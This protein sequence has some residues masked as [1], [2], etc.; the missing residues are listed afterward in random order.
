MMQT[1]VEDE[2]SERLVLMLARKR[3][4]TYLLKDLLTSHPAY[5]NTK[6]ATGNC[7]LATA[8]WNGSIEVAKLLVEEFDFDVNFRNQ[9]GSTPLHQGKRLY[10]QPLQLLS[11]LQP[12]I[13]LF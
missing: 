2:L 10:R 8:C 9:K 5:K 13:S 4:E 11:T 1:T 12:I 6:D 7:L 3:G